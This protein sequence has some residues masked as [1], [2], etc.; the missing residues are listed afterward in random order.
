MVLLVL[1]F[2]FDNGCCCLDLL[3]NRYCWM[4]LSGCWYFRLFLLDLTCMIDC[5]DGWKK[6]WWACIASWWTMVECSCKSDHLNDRRCRF[7]RSQSLLVYLA[8]ELITSNSI[9]IVILARHIPHTDRIDNWCFF[10]CLWG[11]IRRYG[12]LPKML[13]QTFIAMRFVSMKL[14]RTFD[15]SANFFRLANASFRFS[16]IWSICSLVNFDSDIVTLFSAV[17]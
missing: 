5:R 2:P 9:C 3:R 7:E 12:L 1:L 13:T 15:C 17:A 16:S 14:L 6:V 10:R 11:D 4:S 8:Q